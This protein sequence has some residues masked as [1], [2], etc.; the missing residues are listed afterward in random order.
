MRD[1]NETFLFLNFREGQEARN[2]VQQN[3]WKQ[4]GYL[5]N[6]AI[7]RG[8]A[9]KS[10]LKGSKAKLVLD[11]GCAEGFITSFLS[12]LPVYVIGID[13]DES[14]EIAKDKV[15]NTSFIYASITHLPF[16]SQVFE[17]VTCLEV[18]EHL[19]DQTI[20]KG[21]KEIDRVLKSSGTLIISV[22]YKE[23]ITFIRCIHCGKL[24]PLWG[25]I[26]TFDEN[27]VTNLLPGYYVLTKK[28]HMPNV[29]LIS[30]SPP[31]RIL[32]YSLWLILNN[33]LG[34]IR[35]G[36]WIILKYKKLK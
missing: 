13:V 8:Q 15:K 25:H 33:L 7:R 36:V 34:L 2:M 30:C 11:V 35:K 1:F 10:M 32:P 19:Q 14:I 27:K 16:R 23:E 20:D 29:R 3:I 9:V 22:P 28:I 24:T 17:A 4:K 6:R 18:L 21:I 5:L 26:Q 31:F 12:K